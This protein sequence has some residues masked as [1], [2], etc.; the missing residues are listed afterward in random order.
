MRAVIVV[1]LFVLAGC[2]GPALPLAQPAQIHWRE[3]ERTLAALQLPPSRASLPRNELIP[4]VDSVMQ[5]IRRP[6][7]NLCTRIYGSHPHCGI[8]FNA[9]VHVFQDDNRVNAFVDRQNRIGV[10]GGLIRATGTDD[11]LAAVLAHELAHALYGHG[12]STGHNA[13]LGKILGHIAGG[14]IAGRTG[15]NVQALGGAFGDAGTEIGAR[16]YSRWMEIEADHMAAYILHQAGYEATGLRD[17]LVRMARLQGTT[18]GWLATH[19]SDERRIAHALDAITRAKRDVPVT[20]R[21]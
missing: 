19:P 16:S 14:A 13:A 18:G 7:Y 8:V 10:Y 9:P 3:A 4:T 15:G 20:W 6:A 1:A 12:V 5:K 2:A 21:Q 17:M 11:E